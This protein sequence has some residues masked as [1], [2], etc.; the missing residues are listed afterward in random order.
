MP[1]RRIRAAG[2]IRESD[3]RL[4]DS[5]TIESA[6]A[7]IR[8]HCEQMGYEYYQEHEYKEAIS[9]YT[10]R[11]TERERMRDL[12][13]AAKRHEF[14]VVVVT[15]IRA[16]SRRQAE[17]FVIYDTLQR[18]GIRLETCQEQFEDSA[19]GRALLGLR[20]M[21]AEI[22]REQ[23]VMRTQRGRNDRL[24]NGNL[25]GHPKPRY[26][27]VFVDTALEVKARYGLNHQVIFVDT[28]ETEWTEVK[29]VLFIFDLFEAGETIKSIRRILNMKGIPT[30]SRPWKAKEAFWRESTVYSILTCR[31]YIGET[32]VNKATRQRGKTVR[33]PPEEWVTL[34]DVT[35]PLIST[36]RFEHVQAQLKIN[37]T[38]AL[39][40][41]KHPNQL[42]LLR[43]R[44]V[45]GICGG[46]M[47]VKYRP[48]TDTRHS[49]TYACYVNNG[50]NGR[51]HHH[52]TVI[53]LREL[54][55]AGWEKTVE[56]LTHPEQVR[57]RVTKLR[58]QPLSSSDR[59][60]IS[61]TVSLIKRQMKNLYTLAEQCTD[62]D[63]LAEISER[64]KQLEKQKREAEAMLLDIEE[65]DET[66]AEL[67][68][69]LTKFET[70]AT[71]IRPFLTDPSYVPTYEEQRLAARILGLQAVVYPLH[72]DY[73][74]RF[75]ISANPPSIVSLLTHRD[76]R[77]RLS[78]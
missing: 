1:K 77:G 13:D 76:E 51:V 32:I 9:A 33:R 36:E 72:G 8:Q 58:E 43:S 26:G 78:V 12:L 41:N 4:V 48:E 68:A 73:P 34:S 40:N 11:Y 71:T 24:K 62:D 74:F 69:E 49:T 64:M 59:E 55:T 54:D 56:I 17:V 27:Y 5:T 38:E 16:I 52:S 23:I 31:A 57:E 42:G 39:R 45:C 20:A 30:P 46:K 65:E 63:A 61:K 50:K 75:Q 47:G 21:F 53:T 60:S 22:E 66:K 2:Y 19:T 44:C 3:E 7:A 18:Y 25:R 67:D 35:P 14:D 28:D 10:T 15:E 6:A 70:W 37:K 29:V